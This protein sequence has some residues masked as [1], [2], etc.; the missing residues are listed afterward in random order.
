MFGKEEVPGITMTGIITDC[1]KADVK[2]EPSLES[3]SLF[4]I[5]ALTEVMIDKTLSTDEF[6]KIYS[7]SGT[8][9]YCL[10][11]YIAV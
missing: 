3:E 8:E 10:K 2:E 6:Y 4:K 5:D 7:A 1:L 11:K 9:G